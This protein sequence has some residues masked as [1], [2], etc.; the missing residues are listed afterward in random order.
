TWTGTR[1]PENTG[2]PLMISGDDVTVRSFMHRTLLQA[3]SQ[4]QPA[5]GHKFAKFSC[6]T[7]RD[8]PSDRSAPLAPVSRFATSP[9]CNPPPTTKAGAHHARALL[10]L[11]E[12]VTSDKVVIATPSSLIALLRTIALGWCASRGRAT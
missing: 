12:A 3:A 10:A 8:T 5:K 1:V 6:R 11:S 9:C 4:T 2:A 7:I